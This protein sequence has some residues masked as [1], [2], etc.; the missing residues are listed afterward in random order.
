[1]LSL[2]FLA[3]VASSTLVLR[4]PLPKAGQVTPQSVLTSL[5]RSV[6]TKGD[7]SSGIAPDQR[8]EFPAPLCSSIFG[9]SADKRRL[10]SNRGKWPHRLYDRKRTLTLH[11]EGGCSSLLETGLWLSA[12][13]DMIAPNASKPASFVPGPRDSP[14]KPYTRLLC[15]RAPTIKHVCFPKWHLHAEHEA[16]YFSLSSIRNLL[17]VSQET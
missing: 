2:L 10:P 15:N 4:W 9:L 3:E 17:V 16:R 8:V 12:T 7:I 13:F 6:S 11:R 5:F 14:F 1:M